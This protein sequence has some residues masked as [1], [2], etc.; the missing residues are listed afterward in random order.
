MNWNSPEF[1]G[2]KTFSARKDMVWT[3]DI[4]IVERYKNDFEKSCSFNLG[5]KKKMT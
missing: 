3:P 5:I 1:C 2:M 4:V